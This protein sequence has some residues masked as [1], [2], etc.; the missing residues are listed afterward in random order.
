M[1]TEKKKSQPLASQPQYE[2]HERQYESR[3][4][5]IE[6][7]LPKALPRRFKVIKHALLPIACFLV[8]WLILSFISSCMAW[9]AV[10]LDSNQVFFGRF[11]SVPFR[12]TIKVHNAHYLKPNTEKPA[13]G[14]PA[15]MEVASVEDDAHGPESAITVMKSHVLYYQKLRPGTPLYTGLKKALDR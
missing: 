11:A 4:E 6:K 10:F 12:S 1:K 3:Y 13:D 5:P 9:K 2:Q 7:N 15:D 14:K 8:V